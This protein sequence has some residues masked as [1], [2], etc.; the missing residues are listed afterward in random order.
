MQCIRDASAAAVLGLAILVSGCNNKQP[1][2]GANKPP[3]AQ[4]EQAGGFS[5][6][7][8][9]G[10]ETV[11]FSGLKY[12]V[13]HG[14]VANGFAPNINVVDESFAG[15]LKE[16]VDGNLANMKNA[17]ADL[18]IRKREDFQTEDGLSATRVI[19]E[20]KQQGRLLRQTF[21]FFGESKRKYVATCTTLADGG[22]VL[23]GTFAESMRTFRLH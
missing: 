23:D 20:N 19:T 12:R 14:P 21:C 13:S 1:G 17:F 4:Y 15:S 22:E 10:W 6:D 2:A 11:N 8:P 5:Y 9:K 3:R 18:T 16:Y 7:P